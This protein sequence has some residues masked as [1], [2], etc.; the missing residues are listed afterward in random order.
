MKFKLPELP[1]PQTGLAPFLSAETLEFHYGKHHKTYID[2]MNDALPG[3]EFDAMTLEDIVRKSSGPLF[4]NAAQAWNHT[5]YWY[6]LGP[7]STEPTA[8]PL[9]DAIKTNFGSMEEFKKKFSEKTI[10]VFGS[11]WG[12]LVQKPDGK[13]DIVGTSNADCPLKNGDKPLLTADVWEHAYYVDY[14]NLRPKYM[15]TF[16][17]HVN[18]KFVEQNMHSKEM[19]NM[20]ALMK[21]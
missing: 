16:W 1:Y 18:W 19:P 8:G 17:K 3:T 5:F 11:G 9:F 20:T 10:G 13:L 14:R 15:E 12:W 21:A 2:K 6:G 7:A 4:N